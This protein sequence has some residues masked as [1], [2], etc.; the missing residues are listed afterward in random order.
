[1]IHDFFVF[2]QSYFMQTFALWSFAFFLLLRIFGICI[3]LEKM[4]VCPTGQKGESYVVKKN[5]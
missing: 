3:I 1:M 2:C 5:R 4:K